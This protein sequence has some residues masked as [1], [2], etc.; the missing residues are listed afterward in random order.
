MWAVLEPS[1]MLLVK[2]HWQV[3]KHTGNILTASDDAY[4][5][6]LPSFKQLQLFL[7]LNYFLGDSIAVPVDKE[8]LIA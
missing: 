5:L 7:V 8:V 2:N 6:S 4:K 3:L 1:Q